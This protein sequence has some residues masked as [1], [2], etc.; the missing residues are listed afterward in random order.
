MRVLLL[1]VKLPSGFFHFPDGTI[2]TSFKG[3]TLKK[4]FIL[5][6]ITSTFL[7]SANICLLDSQRL[8][9]SGLT[10]VRIYCIDNYKYLYDFDG[11][12]EQM[13]QSMGHPVPCKCP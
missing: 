4:L 11:G 3:I 2:I 12:F 5:L 1:L 13:L 10:S 6:L 7:M 8:P 9:R